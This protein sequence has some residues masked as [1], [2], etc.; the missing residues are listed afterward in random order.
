MHATA[1]REEVV[2]LVD[3]LNVITEQLTRL[4]ELEE[5]IV[6]AARAM[7]RAEHG[8]DRKSHIHTSDDS[9]TK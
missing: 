1:S 8:A 4:I 2:A 9:T 7:L 3:R 6:F 5:R